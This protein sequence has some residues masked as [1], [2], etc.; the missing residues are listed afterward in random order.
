MKNKHPGL[1]D[2]INNEIPKLKEKIKTPEEFNAYQKLI[3]ISAR[4]K[5][6]A[7][8]KNQIKKYNLTQKLPYRDHAFEYIRKTHSLE[9]TQL[10]L[11]SYN[12]AVECVETYIQLVIFCSK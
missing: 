12:K 5:A 1:I 11:T 10:W 4:D 6:L 8:V 9:N 3:W 7:D 2:Q